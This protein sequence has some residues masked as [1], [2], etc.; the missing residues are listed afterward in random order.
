M[1]K[2][3]CIKLN[4]FWIAKETITRFKRLPTDWEK[5]FAN[6]SFDKGLMS[7]IYRE[8]KKLNL[9]RIHNPMKKWHMN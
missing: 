7:R 5:I 6:Y 3:N 8:L 9:P 1:N 2:W 4:N